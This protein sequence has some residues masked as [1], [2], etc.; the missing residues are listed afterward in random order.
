MARDSL[1]SLRDVAVTMTTTTGAPLLLPAQVVA[2][3]THG[4]SAG[5]AVALLQWEVF[6]SLYSV[7]YL[8]HVREG[9][10]GWPRGTAARDRMWLDLMMVV[11]GTLIA[12]WGALA[13]MNVE[14]HQLAG[15]LP[16]TQACIAA[17][18]LLV[19]M[20]TLDLT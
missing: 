2:Q 4:V 19:T 9:Y 3:L 14:R 15:W 5:H 20:R 18:I 17:L 16:L 10:F 1:R 11:D 7:R 8:I 13:F 12:V 6:G